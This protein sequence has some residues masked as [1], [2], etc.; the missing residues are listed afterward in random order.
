[1]EAAGRRRVALKNASQPPLIDERLGHA[2]RQLGDAESSERG[3]NDR[4]HF[5]GGKTPGN[6]DRFMAVW[7]IKH[8]VD[9]GSRRACDDAIVP[10]EIGRPL[11]RSSA[12][13]ILRAGAEQPVG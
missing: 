2:V 10:G 12:R 5:I 4:L 1:M 7:T 11:R 13:Y 9:A 3:R 6:R 8:P